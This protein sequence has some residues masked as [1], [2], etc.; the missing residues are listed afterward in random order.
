MTNT[1][2][3]T[4]STII[5]TVC[6]QSRV[7][8][9]SPSTQSQS[10]TRRMRGKSTWA[11]RPLPSRQRFHFAALALDLLCSGD[12][13]SF[14]GLDVCSSCSNPANFSPHEKKPNAGF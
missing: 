3:D 11:A 9:H 10:W 12:G 2:S 14:V 4:L 1:F 7:G 13:W 5:P 6:P 8:E